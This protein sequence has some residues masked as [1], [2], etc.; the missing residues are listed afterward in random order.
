M[1]GQVDREML[2][3]EIALSATYL[4]CD[5]DKENLVSYF[6]KDLVVQ[7]LGENVGEVVLGGDMYWNAH[8]AVTDDLDP[9][10]AAVDVA[11]FGALCIALHEDLGGFVVHFKCERDGEFESHLF[12]DVVVPKDVLSAVAG[13]IDL[14]CGARSVGMALTYEGRSKAYG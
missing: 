10:L 4:L 14:V 6:F 9:L 5:E 12:D 13:G 11:K 7:D 3:L 2:Q 1:K 8:G